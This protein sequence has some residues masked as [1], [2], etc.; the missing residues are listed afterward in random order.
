MAASSVNPG[1]ESVKSM[2]RFDRIEQRPSPLESVNYTIAYYA[3]PTYLGSG[4][5]NMRLENEPS[6]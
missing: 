6:I 4:A 3:M 1:H 5:G 2:R